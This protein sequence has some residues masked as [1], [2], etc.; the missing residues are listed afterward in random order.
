MEIGV[1]MRDT[2]RNRLLPSMPSN[3]PAS[4]PLFTL[5]SPTTLG[6]VQVVERLCLSTAKTSI[7]LFT[8][9]VS[10]AEVSAE[11]AV[12]HSGVHA[13]QNLATAHVSSLQ[14]KLYFIVGLRSYSAI[15]H[16]N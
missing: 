12:A 6:S 5:A 13:E 1:S 3:H 9:I 14:I 11:T 2:R 15:V 8:N 4:V 16:R 7:D 10:N